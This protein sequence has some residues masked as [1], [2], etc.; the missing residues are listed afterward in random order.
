MLKS[1]PP[2]LTS[3]KAEGPSQHLGGSQLNRCSLKAAVMGNISVSKNGVF[4]EM[5]PEVKSE[6]WFQSGP[7][8]PAAGGQM[9][10]NGAR[11]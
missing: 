3:I 7:R 1:N 11:H 4:E 8:A 6:L 9:Q 5:D 10:H 2:I